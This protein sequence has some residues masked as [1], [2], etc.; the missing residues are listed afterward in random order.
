MA[1][2]S[3]EKEVQAVQEV[4]SGIDRLNS[5]YAPVVNRMVVMMAMRISQL[6]KTMAIMLM[7]KSIRRLRKS[8]KLWQ[9]IEQG[10]MRTRETY[11]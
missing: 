7:M 10:N 2:C 9:D 11:T 1:A 3:N 8:K 6:A 4:T 5:N